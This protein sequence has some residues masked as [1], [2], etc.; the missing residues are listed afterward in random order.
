[1]GQKYR[2][3]YSEP[4]ADGSVLWFAEWLG[5]PTLARIQNCKIDGQDYRLTVY[6]TGEPDT[7]FS[8]PACTRKRGK[9]VNGFLTCED[10][11]WCFHPMDSHKHLLS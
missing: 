6:V 5:G 1:M 2:A 3:D 11:V 10:H 4:Q 9:H 7:Y 8:Q